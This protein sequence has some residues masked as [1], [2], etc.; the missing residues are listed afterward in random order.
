L[1][2]NAWAVAVVA[3]TGDER[4]LTS[5]ARL[6]VTFR[7]KNNAATLNVLEPSG[8]RGSV[9]IPPDIYDRI[10]GT[11]GKP[12]EPFTLELFVDRRSGKGVASLIPSWP[13]VRVP[14]DLM[15]F[16]PQ[17]G[18][19]ITAVGAALADCCAPGATVRVE[20]SD[21]RISQLFGRGYLA[22]EPNVPQPPPIKPL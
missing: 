10:F 19:Q 5:E 18:P 11:G 17:T 3:R 4:D 12:P 22:I 15:T 16:G 21:F 6:A 9:P 20:V 8:S 7:V 13:S 2:T 1:T 14:F